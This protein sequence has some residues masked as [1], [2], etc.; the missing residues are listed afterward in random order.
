MW[1]SFTYTTNCG[2]NSAALAAVRNYAT[3]AYVDA[4]ENPSRPFDI[5]S[6]IHEHREGFPLL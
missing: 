4:K 2:G 6:A 3:L 1:P 5:L